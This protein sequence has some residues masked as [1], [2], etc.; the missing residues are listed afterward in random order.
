MTEASRAQAWVSRAERGSLPL[1]RLGVRTTRIL[2]RRVAR[3]LLYPLCLYFMASS[4]SALRHSRAYLRRALGRTPRPRDHFLHFMTFARCLL[5]RVF[6]LSEQTDAFEITVHGE[7]ILQNIEQQGGG[8]L[9][10]GAHFGSFE[11]ARALGRRRGDLPISLLMYEENAQKIRAALAAINPRLATEVIGLGRLDSLILVAER[12]QRGHFIGVLADRNVEGLDLV[13]HNF[14]GQP[15]GF[16]QGPFRM[17]M[18]L[19][20]PVVMM[21]GVYR[22]GRRY[23]VHFELLGQATARAPDS[24]AWIDDTMRAYVTRLEHYCRAAPYNWSNFYDFW[25]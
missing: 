3:L 7:E 8:C 4:P 1:I 12:L 15:A 23:E 6:L 25:A 10:F 19:R 5:D 21:V 22:G 17:A 9:L 2:G 24:Q 16:P 18:L 14:L 11:V 13:R 20:R